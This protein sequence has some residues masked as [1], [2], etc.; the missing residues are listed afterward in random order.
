MY[1]VSLSIGLCLSSVQFAFHAGDLEI[2]G[3]DTR[4]EDVHRMY[5]I[6]KRGPEFHVLKLAHCPY[7]YTLTLL[8]EGNTHT[9]QTAQ[10]KP[11]GVGWEE[12]EM[13]SFTEAL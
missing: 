12:F 10:N 6:M 7:S 4:P 11:E 8:R 1:V 9:A 2:K 13:V 5:T 3:T